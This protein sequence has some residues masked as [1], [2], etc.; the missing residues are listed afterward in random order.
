MAQGTP[1]TRI[2]NDVVLRIPQEL[3]TS[4]DLADAADIL[5]TQLKQR[6]FQEEQVSFTDLRVF[7]AMHTVLS[8]T[9]SADDLALATGTPGTDALVVTTGDVKTLTVGRKAAFELR[10]PDNYEA[11]QSFQIRIRAGMKTTI[12]DG[13]ATVDLNVYKPVGDGLVGSDLCAT[14]ATSINSLTAS[15]KDFTVTASSLSPGEKLLCIV[16]LAVT[17]TATA[18]AV[19]GQIYSIS[20]RCDTRG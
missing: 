18:T 10:V 6:A 15:D 3:F 16:T 1:M 11:G 2:I 20:R 17:D 8:G 5:H 13:S 7:D 12:A 14:A 4:E 9:S 19:I